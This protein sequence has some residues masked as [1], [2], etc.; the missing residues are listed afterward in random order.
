MTVK[1]G[2]LQ[3]IKEEYVEYIITTMSNEELLRIAKDQVEKEIKSM[4]TEQFKKYTF[5]NC[6]EYIYEDLKAYV[7][8][9]DPSKAYQLMLEIIDDREL[10]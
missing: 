2:D 9:D 3:E 1:T 7:E 5:N 4:D 8:E 6:D 10:A